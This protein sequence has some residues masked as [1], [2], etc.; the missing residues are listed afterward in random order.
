MLEIMSRISRKT[1]TENEGTG[2][3]ETGTIIDGTGTV[4]VNGTGTIIGK[5][6]QDCG[7]ERDR[8]H[9]RWDRDRGGER[10][11]DHHR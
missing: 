1:G 9:H 7:G 11:R 6:N 4:G 3:G 2:I 10:Y 8:D 5:K